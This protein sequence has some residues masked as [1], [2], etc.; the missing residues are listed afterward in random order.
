MK[1]ISVSLCAFLHAGSASAFWGASADSIGSPLTRDEVMQI[2]K[3]MLAV[4]EQSGADAMLA[5]E[6]ACW[7]SLAEPKQTKLV[8]MHCFTMTMAGMQIQMR[9]AAAKKGPSSKNYTLKAVS[10]RIEGYYNDDLDFNDKQFDLA[11]DEGERLQP[12]ITTS[13]TKIALQE[14]KK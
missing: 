8:P 5:V 4:Y 6:S 12:L 3:D 9:K 13:L 7:K 1:L 2:T 10:D 14:L 11:N